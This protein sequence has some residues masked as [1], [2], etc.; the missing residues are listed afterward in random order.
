MGNGRSL[1]H[2][3]PSPPSP[4]SLFPLLFSPIKARILLKSEENLRAD[5]IK[6]HP[7]STI[8]Q[9][10]LWGHFQEKIPARGKYWIVVLEDTTHAKGGH[11][12]DANSSTP[13]IIAGTLLIRHS[14]PKGYC[15]LYTARGPL[16]NYDEKNN[17]KDAQLQMAELLNEIKKIAK[18]EKAIFL[19]VDPPLD[20]Q[21]KLLKFHHFHYIKKGFQQIGR[22]SCRERV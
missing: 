8:H 19:R 5:F 22:A 3:P 15:W 16:L 10:P 11:S 9:D 14:L 20:C 7:F 13:K 17:Y 4:C 12:G 6:N 21:Q 18:Q 2:F 1:W